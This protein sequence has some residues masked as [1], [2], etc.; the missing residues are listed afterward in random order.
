[1]LGDS[2]FRALIET[3][4]DGVVIVNYAGRI[5]LVNSQIEEMFG[6]RR[7]ELIGQPAEMLVPTEL[8]GRHVQHREDFVRQPHVRAMGVALELF[9]QRADGSRFPVEISLSPLAG[10]LDRYVVTVIRDVTERNRL[11]SEA[12]AQ[13]DRQRIADLHD[14][15]IQS[16]YATGLSLHLAVGEIVSDPAS[17]GRRIDESVAGL[18]SAMRD[19]R[20]FIFDLRPLQSSGDLLR[21][22]VVTIEEY[23]AISAM[24]V[25]FAPPAV[26]PAL[27]PDRAAVMVAV[28]REGLSNTYRHAGAAR[29]FVSLD[30]TGDAL[31]LEVRDDGTGFDATAQPLRGHRGIRN[32]VLRAQ[33]LGGALS[34]ESVPG[35]GTTLRLQMPLGS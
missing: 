22:L 3:L 17:A 19:I 12:L 6:Y 35:S 18:V 24:P 34:I 7:E 16:L 25:A 2:I 32:L 31:R 1:M 30:A 33:H 4:P 23:R 9:A 20:A 8:R 14:G 21:D 11:R 13:E 5:E 28:L 26:V 29:A 15:V 10:G 27:Q